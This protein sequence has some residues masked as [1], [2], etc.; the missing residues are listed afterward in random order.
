MPE[1]PEVE[2]FRQLLL[3]LVSD[4]HPLHL[5]RS[6]LDK[7]PPRKFLSDD[8]ILQINTQKYRLSNVL[9][10][11]KLLCMVLQNDQ[12]TKHLFVHMGMTGRISTPDYVP[13]L[14]SLAG[15]DYPPPH[16]YMKFSSGSS[17]EA[18]FSD[19]RKFGFIQVGTIIGEE[20]DSLAPDALTDYE[21]HH[22]R[23]IERLS[24]QSMGIK[25]L[26]LDQKRAVS[27]VG[28]WV[29]D[30]ILY[31]IPM[32]PDQNYLTSEQAS[33]LLERLHM[34]LKVAVDCLKQRQEFPKNWL[35]HYRWNRKKATKDSK[36]RTVTFVTSGGRTSAIVP[37]IQKKK[38]QASSKNKTTGSKRSLEC[39]KEEEND[40]FEKKQKSK[41][42]TDE[43]T[44][45]MH[46]TRKQTSKTTTLI[47]EEDVV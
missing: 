38:S 13:Q 27:G 18:S 40:N 14:E 20:F 33:N 24:D 44:Q 22:S 21:E 36:G 26:L 2:N 25:A 7:K 35:F 16:T 12:D 43:K 29:A 6:N 37:S 34:I 8:D 11:G 4:T 41:P 19:P 32:H 17:T 5:E 30:E 39:T 28:N 3:P 46:K 42:T 10:K 45:T 47:K 31:Q 23:I 15:N 9:R 1:L